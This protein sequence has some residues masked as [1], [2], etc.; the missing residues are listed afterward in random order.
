MDF[1]VAN[2]LSTHLDMDKFEIDVSEY[3]RLKELKE[4]IVQLPEI[5]I[6]KNAKRLRDLS[7][8]A[9][10]AIK[11]LDEIFFSELPSMEVGKL[12]H[13]VQPI[14]GKE[15]AQ[16]L[17]KLVERS[18]IPLDN[19]IYVGDS[20]T[21]V[22]IFKALKDSKGLGVAFNGN[23]YAIQNA[24]LAVI[25]ES[26]L[27][28]ALIAETFVKSGR[29]GV[30]LLANKWPDSL[31]TLVGNKI[32]DYVLALNENPILIRIIRSNMVKIIDESNNFRKK[33][34]GKVIG[35]LG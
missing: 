27:P 31:H 15:K 24:D 25:S 2:T 6:P 1:P 34:R 23:H 12:L 30:F 29:N 5:E 3:E 18:K 4:E 10:T 21:D 13:D 35:S 7:A 28:I 9:I 32:A 16:A 20:I 22:E 8:E 17:Y 26:A 14:G 19:F 11:R 33:V